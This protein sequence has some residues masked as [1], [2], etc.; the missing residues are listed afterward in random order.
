MS[1]K[2]LT[3]YQR[4]AL[5]KHFLVNIIAMFVVVFVLTNILNSYFKP[6]SFDIVG[7]FGDK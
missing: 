7:F 2:I 4:H 5:Y 1:L 3:Y 6:S